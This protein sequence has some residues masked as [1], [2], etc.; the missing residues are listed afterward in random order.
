MRKAAT[1]L[2]IIRKRGQHGLP[3]HNV[4]RLLYK[5]DLY[6]LAYAKLYRN[7]GAMTQG[8]SSETV[9]G[10]SLEKIDTI[11]NALRYER[12]KWAPMKRVYIPKK[13]GKLRQLGLPN[14][15]DKLLQEVIRLIMDAYY[16]PQ[17]SSH[18][19]G[20]RPKLG[21]HS[22]LRAIMKKG[23]G[24]KWFIEGDLCAC[25][26]SIDHTI[27]I[28]LIKEKFQDNRFIRLISWLLKAGYLEAWKLNT[29]YSGV[30]Q[31]SIVGPIFSNI[32]LDC[33]DKYVERELIPA[34]TCGKRRKT[35]LPYA[36]LTLQASKARKQGDWKRADRLHK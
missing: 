9:D 27:L 1:I 25:F 24:T 4:Y 7:N 31:G 14:W 33:L 22:A 36:R 6:L 12:Y 29:T 30:P 23:K 10:M 2:S 32:V 20:F 13:N 35:S 11:I 21:C 15:S 16:E 28:K 8:V 3:I 26:D 34:H 18:S 19:Y 5:K 17:F